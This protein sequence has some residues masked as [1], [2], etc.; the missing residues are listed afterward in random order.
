MTIQTSIPCEPTAT[1]VQIPHADATKAAI[2]CTMLHGRAGLGA[3]ARASR[4]AAIACHLHAWLR[5][6]PVPMLGVYWPIRG[7]PDL[8][9]LYDVLVAAGVQLALP[10]VSKRQSPLQ[11]L[12]WTPGEAMVVDRHGIAIPAQA[13]PVWPQALLIAC[14]AFD[15]RGFRLGYGGGFYDRTLAHNPQPTA[16]G[17]AY[18][19]AKTDFPVA[20]HDIAM[21]LVITEEGIVV[22]NSGAPKTSAAP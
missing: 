21:H 13:A 14:V 1:V 18:G 10:K 9:P 15:A 19:C 3:S 2:R 17:I 7:E 12:A 8:R 11:F 6:F 4:D 16:I 5:Q 22:A 20:Q